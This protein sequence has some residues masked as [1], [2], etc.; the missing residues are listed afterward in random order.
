MLRKITKAVLFTINVL[1]AYLITS[2]LEDLILEKAHELK[3]L[4]ATAVGMVVIVLIFVPLFT[5]TEKITEELMKKTLK[6]SK[7]TLGRRIGFFI[8]TFIAFL[9]LYNIFLQ[10]WFNM[11]L[12]DAVFR[13]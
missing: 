2:A 7:G 1:I 9:I 11:G 3:P 12:V 5:L 10:E 13:K 8:F 4:V 6:V